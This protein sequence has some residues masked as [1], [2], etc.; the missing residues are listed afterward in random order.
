MI[1][2]WQKTK[3]DQRAAE[4]L[5]ADL[6]GQWWVNLDKTLGNA[7]IKPISTATA[8]TVIEAYEWLGTMPA[9]ILH[10]YGIY[11]D[12]ALGGAVVYSPEYAENLGVWDSYGYTGKIICLTRGAC[13]HWTPTGSASRLI[14]KSMKLLPQ[15][16]KVITATVDAEAGEVGT[17][18]QASN[19][20]YVGLMSP[21]GQRVSFQRNGKLV[22]GRQAQ[23]DFGTRGMAMAQRGAEGVKQ[24]DR[25][26]RYF[27]Y[28]GGKTER[29]TL[30][31][32]MAHKVI[33]YPK[34]PPH[35]VAVSCPAGTHRDTPARPPNN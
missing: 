10:C 14:R 8:A 15:R 32:A 27:A 28:R 12:G 7:T 22:S 20:D 13:A 35:P 30:R 25:K 33:P 17:I 29:R 6:F 16:Y 18:Y 26:G 4:D 5:D 9:I 24:H 11:F 21:G 2:A 23:R 1:T 34:R 3:R 19:F 31:A